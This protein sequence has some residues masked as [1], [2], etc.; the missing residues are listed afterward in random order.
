MSF[1]CRSKALKVAPWAKARE[2]TWGSRTTQPGRYNEE[3]FP[4]S[5][6]TLPETNIA[7]KNGWLEY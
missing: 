5:M 7:P 1:S 2:L 4:I 3:S 6:V